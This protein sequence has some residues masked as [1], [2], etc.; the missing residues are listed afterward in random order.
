M[1][2]ISS[3]S[4]SHNA[5][6]STEKT[7]TE[8]LARKRSLDRKAQ[9]AARSRTKWTIENL[10]YQVAELNNTL[11][12]E[13]SKWQSILQESKEETDILRAENQ[14]LRL[15]LEEAKLHGQGSSPR[16][17]EDMS[18]QVS[19]F[20]SESA[21]P[22]TLHP[23][24]AVPWNTEPTCVSD[25]IVQS[26]VA[27]A[28][29]I[30]HATSDIFLEDQ[31]DLNALLGRERSNGSA[32]V[33]NVVSDILLAY[34]EIGTLPEK[35]ACLYVMYKLLNWLIYRTQ[36]TYDKMPI[37]LRPVPLQLQVEHP[38]WIDRI[39]WPS[40]RVHLIQ[41][42]EITFDDFASCYSSSFHVSW[43]YDH[44]H[45]LIPATQSQIVNPEAMSRDW[46][47][48]SCSDSQGKATVPKTAVLNPVFEQH[49]RQ[50]KNWG[51]SDTFR[52]RFP[53]LSEIMDGDSQALVLE[54]S[55]AANTWA[56]SFKQ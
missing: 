47:S 32:D 35:A 9:Q 20:L 43:P 11:I 16:D 45:V 2:D 3:Q 8:R 23:Y 19:I 49:L 44:A 54:G 46:F 37:W 6:T 5:R 4:S 52:H 17:M 30:V 33:S 7:V 42:P 40:A 48:S 53:E 1:S 27:T 10:Q 39:P 55:V 18:L 14:A 13:T 15:E 34:P 26:H 21:A 36:S 29:T 51:V 31:P 24:E 38:A 12:S 41:H 56:G 22:A 28:S 50:L 25:K